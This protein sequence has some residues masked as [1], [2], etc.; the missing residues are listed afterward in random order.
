MVDSLFES[1]A[2]VY[3][4]YILNEQDRNQIEKAYI[5]AR[6]SHQGQLR[7]SGEPYITHP[8][9]VAIILANLGSGPNTLQ[10]ALLHDVV[11][12]T[13][14]TLIDLS[15][16]FGKDVAFIVDGVTKLTKLEFHDA[17]S[18]ADNHQ[19]MLIAMAKDIRVILIKIADRLH[20]MR[21]LDSMPPENQ[22]RIAK[23]TL[24]IYAP[25]AH[26]LGLFVIKAELEDRALKYAEP[27]KYYEVSRLIQSK[28]DEREESI[29]N[30]TGVIDKLLKENGL[31]NYKIKG[32]IKNIYSIYKKMYINNRS[33]EDIYD[34]LAIRI[35]VD[36]VESCYQSLGLIHANFTPIP[37]RFKDYIAVPK[38]NLYQSLHTTV[39]FNDGTLFEVQIRTKEMD[40]VAELGVAAHWAYKEN[41]NYSKEREQFEMAQ[42]LKWYGELLKMSE[43]IDDI[44]SGSEEFVESVKGDIL[45][46]NVYVFTPKG[47]VIELPKGATPIDFAY[48]I[49]SDVGNKMVGAT[50][51]N[52]IV[53]LDS[54]LKTGDIVSVRTNKSSFGPSESWLKIAKSNHAKH[55]IKSFLNKKN[56]EI[57]AETGKDII[58]RELNNNKISEDITDEFVREHFSKNGVRNLEDLYVEIAKN[59]IS[60][61]TIIAKIV[62]TEINKEQY[63]QR[64]MEKTTRAIHSTSETGV[65]VEGLTNPQIK[66]GSC[67]FPIPGDNI[68]G[69]VS[70][71]GGIV[72]HDINCPNVISLD[73]KRKIEVYWAAKVDRKF[74]TL[75]KIIGPSK[76]TF[77]YD[78]V[79]IVNASNVNVAEMNSNTTQSLETVIKLKILIEDKEKLEKL[80]A[81]IQKVSDVYSVERDYR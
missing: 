73:Q 81:N 31:T 29:N 80:I 14:V 55:K 76:P 77:L 17:P 22:I 27:A 9:A 24:E 35:I 69:Y 43:D 8:V 33:F 78:I 10:A 46:A 19:K 65:I 64:Q 15:K 68:L 18:Q 26:K 79:K 21:T 1:L 51:N 7:K 74:P 45:G 11:E 71:V 25:I 37:R 54:E 62:G 57:L 60:A 32:R 4:E 20:N 49:H 50:V 13:S 12:D 56:A 36:K 47:E 72:V 30:I 53:S 34:L 58:L 75:L 38:P 3:E 40:D 67:C 44:S 52:K 2:K 70:K 5:L 28:K 42:K 16:E 59:N 39:L 41:K 66:L 6:N 63:L 61:K 48:R 23:E